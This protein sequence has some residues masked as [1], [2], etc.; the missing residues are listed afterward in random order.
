MTC[1]RRTTSATGPGRDQQRCRSPT[2]GHPN[3]KVGWAIQ[4]GAEFK[5]DCDHHAG[6][7]LRLRRPLR[8][9]CF[10]LR[11]RHQPVERRPVRLRQQGCV[12]L[13]DRCGLHGRHDRQHR[14]LRYRRGAF[15]PGKLPRGRHNPGTISFPAI[16]TAGTTCNAWQLD[17]TTT[18][19]VMAGYEHYWTPTLK[20]SFTAPATP[21]SSTTTPPR[22][23][24]RKTSALPDDR[25][26][27]RRH[28]RRRSGLVQ[29]RQPGHQSSSS[30]DTNASN[31]LGALLTSRQSIA[32]NCNPDWGFFQGGIR[33]QWN[34][35]SPGFF[36]GLDVFYT[37]VFTAFKEPRMRFSRA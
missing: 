33:T 20:T 26:H 1:R 19:T 36:L 9:G 12:R 21:R 28:H 13:H 32:D 5:M 18:W 31:N 30:S 23:S 29:R 22:R 10:R 6:R 25:G 4:T 16:G 35:R 27:H 17:L 11:R 8:P 37:H 14:E 2:C 24:L 15:I 3:D 7:P 34:R